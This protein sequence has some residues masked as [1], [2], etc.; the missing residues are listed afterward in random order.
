MCK[1]S[2]INSQCDQVAESMMHQL[3]SAEEQCGSRMEEVSGRQGDFG[4]RS[5]R[6]EDEVNGRPSRLTKALA[7]VERAAASIAARMQDL[8]DSHGKV[9]SRFDERARAIHR[10]VAQ[11]ACTSRQPR[12]CCVHFGCARKVED[13]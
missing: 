7:T 5:Q 2:S 11:R 1:A 12:A 3:P 10:I 4:D 6:F 13:P 8:E 9:A